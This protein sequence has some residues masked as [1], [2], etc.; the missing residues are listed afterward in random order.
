MPDNQ[1]AP[2]DHSPPHLTAEPEASRLA[3]H[4]LP[5]K[6]RFAG[7]LFHARRRGV[8]SLLFAL[9]RPGQAKAATVKADS[10]RLNFGS[11]SR[12]IPL[13][14]IN[15]IRLNS[16]WRWG[17][18]RL[19]HSAGGAIVSG[20]ARTEAGALASAIETATAD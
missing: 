7:S 8:A 15:A 10:V 20:L 3:A 16:G 17:G 2:K 14:D 13:S 4:D 12:E 19:D 11:R 6:A 1:L 5:V 18:T 9:F